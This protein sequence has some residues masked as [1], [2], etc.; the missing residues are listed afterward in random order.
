MTERDYMNRLLNLC[1]ERQKAFFDRIYPEGPKNN[2]L[3]TAIS[4][5]E[6][7]LSN[8]D[9]Q[10]EEISSMKKEAAE[11]AEKEN[12]IKA[13]YRKTIT[14]L[15]GELKD[16]KA[17][18]DRLSNPINL[19]NAEVQERLDLLSALEAGGVDN[20]EWYDESINNFR[21]G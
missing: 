20:W 9:E 17:Q 4:Q 5:I 8:L 18:I 12:K 1:T 3:K 10:K 21:N 11:L 14:Q 6:R 7:T 2:Q 19:E 13:E 16:A 15:E